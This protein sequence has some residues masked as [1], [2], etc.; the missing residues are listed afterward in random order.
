[1]N[2]INFSN[3]L[4]INKPNSNTIY[5]AYIGKSNHGATVR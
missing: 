3:N 5:K 4:I 2:L 1:M